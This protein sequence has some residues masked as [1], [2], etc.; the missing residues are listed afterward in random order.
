MTIH[1]YWKNK[2]LNF[3]FCSTVHVAHFVLII[4][5]LLQVDLLAEDPTANYNSMSYTC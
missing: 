4:P 3:S 5:A 1:H 2:R